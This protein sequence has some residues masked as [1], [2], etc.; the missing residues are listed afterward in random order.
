M[1][2]KRI[3]LELEA[4]RTLIR[5]TP[6]VCKSREMLLIRKHLLELE[7]EQALESPLAA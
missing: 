1:D 3:Q 5:E 7:L 2:L 4:T 6:V